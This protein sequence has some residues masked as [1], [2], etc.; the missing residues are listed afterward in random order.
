M[1]IWKILVA[2]VAVSLITLAVRLPITTT[3]GFFIGGKSGI[4]PDN[5]FETSLVDEIRLRVSGVVPRVVIIWFVEIDN[6][7]YVVGENDSGWVTRLGDGGEVYVRLG[8][9]TYPLQASIVNTGKPNI[10]QAWEEKY[11]AGY[12][13]FF[14]TSASNDFLDSSSIYKLSR[15]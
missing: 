12:P 3:P 6:D 2:L 1:K 9:I 10:V 11:S 14:S 15:M 7:F 8:E 5:W 13:E 4:A